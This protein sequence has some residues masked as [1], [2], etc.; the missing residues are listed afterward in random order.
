MAELLPDLSE[1]V[2]SGEAER[3]R[4]ETS[5]AGERSLCFFRRAITD[6][7][8]RAEKQPEFKA[9][10]TAVGG[11]LQSAGDT[12]IPNKTLF[13]MALILSGA[14]ADDDRFAVT[15]D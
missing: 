3:L 2:V 13:C 4:K 14:V 6:V 12:E 10:A 5:A 15:V 7:A 8:R 1:S 9:T 11:I